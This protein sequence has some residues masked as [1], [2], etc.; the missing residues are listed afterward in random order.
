MGLASIR[1]PT[2]QLPSLNT[3]PE[4]DGGKPYPY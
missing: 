3:R 4:P 1:F 2:T